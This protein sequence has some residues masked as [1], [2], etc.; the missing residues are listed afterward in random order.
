MKGSLAKVTNYR[1]SWISSPDL[2]IPST[3][4]LPLFHETHG[5]EILGLFF[6]VLFLYLNSPFVFWEPWARDSCSLAIILPAKGH[7]VIEFE[8]IW[9]CERGEELSPKGDQKDRL[10]LPHWGSMPSSSMTSK[11]CDQRAAKGHTD[12]RRHSIFLDYVWTQMPTITLLIKVGQERSSPSRHLSWT[13]FAETL[14]LILRSDQLRV[15]KMRWVGSLSSFC[16]LRL[17]KNVIDKEVFLGSI[18]AYLLYSLLPWAEFSY[19]E[20]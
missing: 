18:I 19:L 17:L 5:R 3:G 7:L 15:K 1:Q 11:H 20:S 4:F 10:K 14:L 2:L 16:L 6:P 13:W 9:P 8:D 12:Q